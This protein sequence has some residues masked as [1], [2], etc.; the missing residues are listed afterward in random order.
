MLPLCDIVVIAFALVLEPAG[1]ID[2]ACLD[3]AG[4]GGAA[5]DVWWPCAIHAGPVPA[6]FTERRW[7][8]LAV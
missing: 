6:P 8:Q 7:E 1:L 2:P 5:L 4:S 3:E